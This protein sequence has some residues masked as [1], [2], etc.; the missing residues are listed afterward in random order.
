MNL[1]SLAQNL[2]GPWMIHPQQ[3]AAMLPLVRGI[4][5]GNLAELDNA[6]RKE[7]KK[8]S[9]AEFYAGDKQQLNPY[10]DKSVYVTYLDGTMTKY[11]SCYSYGTREIA[12][13]LLEAD[14]DP[15]I[16]G[17]IIVADSGGGAADSVPEL[18]SAIKQLSK[19]IVS[20]IDGMAASACIYAISYTQKII[21]HQAF[22]Q[23]GCIG[24]MITVS[25]WPKVRRDADGYV[26]V[27][28][29]ADQSADKNAD[30]EAAL[31]GNTQIIK[32]ELLNPLCQAFIDDMKENRPS[33]SEDQ[34]TGKTYFAK[35]VVGTLIDAIGSFEDAIQ[36]VVDLAAAQESN[37]QTSETMAK[38]PKLESIPELEEQVYAEDGSTILQECQLEAI[39][40]A[41]TTPRA[42][43]NELQS[44]VDTLKAEHAAEISNL[45]ESITSKNAQI[46]QKD[47][48]I[49]ELETAL[50]AAI[51]KNEEEA[52]AGVHT[53][54]DPANNVEGSS[55]AK[56]WDEA[57]NA[58]R[59]FL[60]RNK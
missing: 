18:A 52:P 20:F 27:R 57:A 24:T 28:I 15:D 32:E 31:E 47:A 55:P 51:A 45:Q 23:V 13:E 25:G 8:V 44:Q 58:C 38:Y 48:R 41:L 53:E 59:E 17:H 35:D 40:Q 46:E 16:I 36:A 6:E 14:K 5:S 56:T 37:N 26:Q 1:S 54:S 10:T 21:A 12:N 29:Y 11:G 4:L 3:A 60:N 33:A 42:E 43:E 34:L 50:A 7:A 9:C 19:P 30:Y 22:D 39:E 49:S 2:R